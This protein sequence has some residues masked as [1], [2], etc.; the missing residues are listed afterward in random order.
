MC[1]V[2]R[3]NILKNLGATWLKN[4]Q[5]NVENLAEKLKQVFVKF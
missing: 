1:S 5:V 3:K 2:R 4:I